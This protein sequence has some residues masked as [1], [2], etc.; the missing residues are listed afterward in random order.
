MLP[1]HTVERTSDAALE[2]REIALRL[3]RRDIAARI[4]KFCVVDCLVS[5]LKPLANALIG[6]QL[7][8]LNCSRRLNMIADRALQ[9]VCGYVLQSATNERDRRAQL[10]RPLWSSY[11]TG[12]YGASRP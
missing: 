5:A 6:S 9:G 2:R 8:R 4:F 12:L 7:V 3:I 1:A 10:T 11:R